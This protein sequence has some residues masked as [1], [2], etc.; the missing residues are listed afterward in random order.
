MA[1]A[2]KSNGYKTGHVGKWH[3]GL[4]AAQYGFD[5]VDH[6]RGFHRGMKDRTKDFATAT[7]RSYPLSKEDASKTEL[8]L[9]SKYVTNSAIGSDEVTAGL[10][11]IL[12][13][14]NFRN[15]SKG[16]RPSDRRSRWPHFGRRGHRG[17]R[18][19]LGGCSTSWRGTRRLPLLH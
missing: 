17:R 8:F 3:I 12:L 4:T 16:R 9:T 6:D 10:V 19:G 13:E 18:R 11:D 1:D 15:L 14:A 2:M 7:D 5:F